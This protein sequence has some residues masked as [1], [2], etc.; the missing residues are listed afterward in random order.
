M[1]LSIS[2]VLILVVMSTTLSLMPGCK[3]AAPKSAPM[4]SSTTSSAASENA[5]PL[6]SISKLA[7][8]DHSAI[9]PAAPKIDARSFALMDADSGAFIAENNG[10]A[11][12]EPASL[13]KLMTSY[14]VFDA[15]KI[16]KLK[17]D[18]MVTISEHAWKTGG[19]VTDGST[20]FL[21]IGERVSVE[22]LIQGM[23][24]Q[25]GNDASIALAER[26]AGSE[27]TFAQ[28]MRVYAQRLNMNNSSFGNATGLPSPL[29]YSTAHDLALLAQ[30]LIRDFPQYY[31]YFS[32]KEFTYNKMTQHNRNGL[33]LRDQSVDGLKTGHTEAAGYCLISSAKREGMR[34]IAVVM[35][36][37]SFKAREDSSQALLNY[38]F[39]FFET[40]HLFK[41]NQVVKSV[42]VRKGVVNNVDVTPG[43]DIVLTIPRGRATDIQTQ[44][45]LPNVLIAPLEHATPV[46]TLS[47][48]LD[49]K[50]IGH[51]NLYP[52]HDVAQAGFFGRTIDSIKLLFSH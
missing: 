39:S 23:I 27:D 17:L 51:Y 28:L 8:P 12:V 44:I 4:L 47:L 52:A 37:N 25:S 24:I 33:L 3:K 29:G 34:L 40:T 11:R 20:S 48:S 38:G 26:I 46:G 19:A 15:L 2:N 6:L 21:P 16:G 35:G 49:S 22:T 1:N 13:T 14:I 32:I 30:A 43:S 18:D 36:T 7:P 9:I 10:D 42:V 31:H 45:N 5:S 41:G 50:E